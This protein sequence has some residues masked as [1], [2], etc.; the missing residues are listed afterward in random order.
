[1]AA[2]EEVR[3]LSVDRYAAAISRAETGL[4]TL[5]TGADSA[6]VLYYQA[7]SYVQQDDMAAAC[8]AARRIRGAGPPDVSSL[9]AQLKANCP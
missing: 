6:R 1:T 2:V 5:A 3:R 7:F 9:I 8:R 4:P